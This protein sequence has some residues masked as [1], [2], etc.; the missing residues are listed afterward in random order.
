MAGRPFISLHAGAHYAA[1]E[2]LYRY[3]A[4]NRAALEAAGY[5]VKA[6]EGVLDGGWAGAALPD[7]G[8]ALPDLNVY[9]AGLAAALRPVAAG[10]RR[11]LVLSRPDLAGTA[12]E[13]L[14]GRFFPSAGLRGTALRMALGARVDTMVFAIQPYD[15]FFLQAWRRAAIEGAVGAFDDYT[16]V[17]AGFAG[18]WVET[19]EALADALGA[20]RVVV[21]A[22][23]AHDLR[24]VLPALMPEADLAGTRLPEPPVPVTDSAI[25]MFQRHLKMG[26]PFAPGQ[27]ERLLA[28]HARLPQAKMRAG[29]D[30][31]PLADMRGRYVG[32]MDLLGRMAGV[33][34]VG[35][36]LA[37]I[38]A[39]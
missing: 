33:E 4:A 3:V 17:M 7:A 18:G 15:Q 14:G 5:A 30:W 32:D 11:G 22:A 2:A 23:A 12:A 26:T 38:A 13:I 36:P 27:R 39:E 16:K 8:V 21:T 20:S 31:L 25:A 34:V 10:A 19:V 28:F 24:A 29:F 37:A 9:A 35:S 1:S 6:P